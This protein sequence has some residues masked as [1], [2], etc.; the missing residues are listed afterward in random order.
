MRTYK[1]FE[2][3]YDEWSK[4]D[5]LNVYYQMLEVFRNFETFIKAKYGDD[6]LDGWLHYLRTGEFKDEELN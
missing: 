2:K 6:Y 4:E 5:V 3:D 1:E